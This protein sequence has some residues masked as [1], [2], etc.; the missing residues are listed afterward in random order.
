[1]ATAPP[2][3]SLFLKRVP[4]GF[5]ASKLVEDSED[6]EKR[7]DGNPQPTAVGV[8]AI[9]GEGVRSAGRIQKKWH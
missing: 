1:M 6:E 4:L 5:D 7:I 9:Q 3:W 2:R 8:P